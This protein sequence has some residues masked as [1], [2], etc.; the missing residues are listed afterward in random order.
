MHAPD[1]PDQMASGE[2]FHDVIVA[3]CVQ[4]G[5]RL[6]SGSAVALTNT[7]FALG[8]TPL[9]IRTAAW[10]PFMMRQSDIHENHIGRSVRAL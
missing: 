9:M 10:M 6:T 8:A 5:W 7:I 1:R 3:A 4:S 2:R